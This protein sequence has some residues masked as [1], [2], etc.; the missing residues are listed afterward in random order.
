MDFRL[1]TTVI[2][3]VLCISVAACATACAQKATAETLGWDL[4]YSSLLDAN[5]VGPNE[6]IRKWLGS[7]YQSPVKAKIAA[8]RH[9]PIE[10]SILL[11]YPAPH[12]GERITQWFVRTKTAAYYY[13]RVEG[14]DDKPP[15]ETEEPLDVQAYDRFLAIVSTWE[16]AQPLRPEETLN[17]DMANY[18]GF[19]SMYNAGNSRQMLLIFRDFT[20][21]ETKNCETGKP[22]RVYE[23]LRTI[24]RF[25]G[26]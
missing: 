18:K 14:E 5:G 24:P 25:S 7:N 26:R 16:Q 8:W 20:V 4:S 6:W 3:A 11:E 23:A 15:H 1:I 19:L 21:C 9:G 22:G 10:S 17:R 13:E 2:Q 12:A